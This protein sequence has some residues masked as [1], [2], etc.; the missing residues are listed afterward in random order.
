MLAFKLKLN[1]SSEQQAQ[2]DLIF[3]K[4]A[5]MASRAAKFEKKRWK[6]EVDSMSSTTS[7]F[8]K[9]QLVHK[10]F[11][12]IEAAKKGMEHQKQRLEWGLRK[13]ELRLQDYK[14]LIDDESAR[15]YKPGGRGSFRMAGRGI[16]TYKTLKEWQSEYEKQERRIYKVKKTLDKITRVLEGKQPVQFK[17]TRITL[18]N[19]VYSLD[20]ANKLLELSLL[21]DSKMSIPF[22]TA[23]YAL[24]GKSNKNSSEFIEESLLNFVKFALHTGYLYG[25]SSSEKAK[26]RS[27]KPEYAEK[28]LK[29]ISSKRDKIKNKFP[30]FFNKVMKRGISQEEQEILLKV[31][32][33]IVAGNDVSTNNAYQ[34]LLEQMSRNILAGDIEFRPLKYPILI[35][36]PLPSKKYKKL[37]NLKPQEWKYYLQLSYEPFRQGTVPEKTIMGIDRGI[38]HLVAVSVFDP[39]SGKFILNKLIDNP[40]RG[41]KIKLRA[42]KAHIRNRERRLRAKKNIHIKE[43]QAKKSLRSLRNKIRNYT[44][45]IS[46]V[47]VNDAKRL[48]AAIVFE[49]L[50]DVKRSGRKK[51]KFTK[52]LDYTLSLFDY[53]Q[54]YR[55][56]KYKAIKEGIQV[57]KVKPDYTSQ[58]CAKCLLTGFSQSTY[59]RGVPRKGD[60]HKINSKVGVCKNCCGSGKDYTIDADLNAARVIAL[61]KFKNLNN[62]QP[63]N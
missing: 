13:D 24:R 31:L 12:D 18:W 54:I 3:R 36:K 57:Y 5:Y 30:K 9:T 43:N 40:V 58:R 23:P 7:G 35:R 42:L 15:E 6:K 21:K 34:N 4:W 51:S 39:K 22:V 46:R 52:N 19:T 17:P 61:C 48:N 1:P 27:N 56:I 8:G 37:K 50:F 47:I 20:F 26:L 10:I 11:D 29:I 53:G 59:I 14:L 55:M 41:W 32:D 25:F 33:D 49:D 44:H 60:K 38:R 16:G 28:K 2:L 62:P 63:D 45:E